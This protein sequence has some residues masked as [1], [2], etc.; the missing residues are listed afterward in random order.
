M[1]SFNSHFCNFFKHCFLPCRKFNICRLAILIIFFSK[2]TILFI[3]N[4]T[5][6]AQ[7][8]NTLEVKKIEAL[9]TLAFEQHRT[10][11]ATSLAYAKTSR[12]ISQK[13]GYP[14]GE[15]SALII[16][17]I[18]YKG[19][20]VYDKA[21][22]SNFQAL[23]ISEK[24]GDYKRK[25]SSLNNIGS[26][27][28]LQENYKKALHYYQQS[29]HIEEAI[30]NKEQISIRLYNIGTVY[31]ALDS[32]QKAY[33][34]YYNSLLI[35]EEYNNK[36]GIYFALYGIAGLDIKTGKFESAQSNI[37]R[38]LSIARTTNN[39]HGISVCFLELGKLYEAKNELS[40]AIIAFDSCI[41]YANKTSQLIEIKEAN[42]QLASVWEKNGNIEN[43]YKHLKQYV[44]MN[45]TINSI[46]LKTRITEI[47]S[48]FQIDKKESEINHLIELNEIKTLR[49]ETERK[50]RNYLLITILLAIILA[51]YNLQRVALRISKALILVII[52]LSGLLLISFIVWFFS[53]IVFQEETKN[54]M[55]IFLD[56]LSFS[57]LPIFILIFIAE[58]VLLKRFLRK[59]N[60]LTT[61][62]Q[63]LSIPKAQQEIE[64]QFD[65]KESNLHFD[66][67][68]LICFEA[69]DNYV[70]IYLIIDGSLKKELRRITLKKIEDQ[71]SHMDKIIRCHKSYIINLTMVSHI[72][73]N[74]QGYKLHLQ[75]IDFTIPVSRNFPKSMIEKIKSMV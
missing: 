3:P 64:L 39:K 67:T 2:S 18:T 50:S 45:D 51:V 16:M 1:K 71:L 53:P 23:Q 43:A 24:T 70:E 68:N 11:P 73:G 8:F 42:L 17:G 10:N 57:I 61:Q 38:A 69:N 20:G 40:L 48:R 55:T 27:F 6:T 22:L 7:S 44:E 26:I 33:T 5:L 37:Q 35:E 49:A 21:I 63:S 41:F 59:A 75:H 15:I 32:I 19:I 65:T 13:I 58:R 52:I 9:N 14:A 47:E 31:E 56:T 60:E 34:Y 74:A 66:L 29:L 46:S 4:G 25:S 72:S 54:F 62:L 12:S 36:E 28:Q 30:G